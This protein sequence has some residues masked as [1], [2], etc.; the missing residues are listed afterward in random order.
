MKWYQGCSG[1]SGLCIQRGVTQLN[2]PFFLPA[3][4]WLFSALKK[5]LPRYMNY[6]RCLVKD[7]GSLL[8]SLTSVLQMVGEHS[9]YAELWVY[10]CG[11]MC[12]CMCIFKCPLCQGH[13]RLKLKGRLDFLWQDACYWG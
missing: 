13:P 8:I 7:V 1:S 6:I 4:Y 12:T 3:V 5:G 9:K 2:S 10:I 11:C